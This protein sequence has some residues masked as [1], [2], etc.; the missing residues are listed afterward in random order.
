M[1]N[2][3]KKAFY[4]LIGYFI[5][6]ALVSFVKFFI[7]DDVTLQIF[8]ILS[9]SVLFFCYFC[10]YIFSKDK[11]RA[12]WVESSSVIKREVIKSSFTSFLVFY[13]VL[14]VYYSFLG[15]LSLKF[16]DFY[17][18]LSIEEQGGVILYEP[19]WNIVS[20]S[21]LVLV[22]VFM[23]NAAVNYINSNSESIVNNI[24]NEEYEK[25]LLKYKKEN[26][27]L[28]KEIKKSND[29]SIVEVKNK[30]KNKNVNIID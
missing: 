10:F 15:Y 30:N 14:Q 9:F 4:S 8:I 11:K 16:D 24:K 22:F 19:I 29:N 2:S 28:K 20:V 7:K 18:R 5:A 26:S 12:E 21:F 13:F 17:E 3:F 27:L 25:E 1:K 6:L 23:I